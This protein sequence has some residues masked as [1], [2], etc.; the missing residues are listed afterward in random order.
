MLK[1]AVVAVKAVETKALAMFN[2]GEGG[3]R[4]PRSLSFL[5]QRS[6]AL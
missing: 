5:R 3:F 1:K 4:E 2:S 6:T